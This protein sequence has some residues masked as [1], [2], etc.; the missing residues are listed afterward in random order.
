VTSWLS[1]ECRAACDLPVLSFCWL[2]VLLYILKFIKEQMEICKTAI[3]TTLTTNES[4]FDGEKKAVF[5][6]IFATYQLGWDQPDFLVLIV[7]WQ[8]NQYRKVRMHL[9]KTT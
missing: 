3:R 9:A 5:Q 4:R 8:W 2:N 1:L 6:F 7:S